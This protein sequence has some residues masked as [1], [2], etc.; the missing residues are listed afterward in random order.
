MPDGYWQTHTRTSHCVAL[1]ADHE[2]A[3]P[4]SFA[5]DASRGLLAQFFQLGGTPEDMQRDMTQQMQRSLQM[6]EAVRAARQ[7]L[8]PLFILRR[9]ASWRGSESYAY[10]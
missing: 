4:Q 8:N 5:Q 2:G 10:L 6:K 9:K 3:A 1:C 7:L